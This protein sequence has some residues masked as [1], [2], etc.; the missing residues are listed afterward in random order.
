MRIFVHT[1]NLYKPEKQ[2]KRNGERMHSRW[3]G[4]L[5]NLFAEARPYEDLCIKLVHRIP[6]SLKWPD[7]LRNPILFRSI[8]SHWPG[9]L[10]KTVRKPPFFTFLPGICRNGM[11][12]RYPQGILQ[13][14]RKYGNWLG[15]LRIIHQSSALLNHPCFMIKSID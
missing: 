2:L 15:M 11:R 13:K 10:R 5:R 1:H 9:M 3:P 8:S 4:M 6:T 12:Y 14:W 7:M